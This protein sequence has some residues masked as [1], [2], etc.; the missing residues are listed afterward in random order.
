MKRIITAIW[1]RLF[2]VGRYDYPR[3]ECNADVL[4]WHLTQQQQRMSRMEARI[5]ALEAN[6]RTVEDISQPS[7]N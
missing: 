5:R 3:C 4:A 7:V 2:P 6:Q 1:D